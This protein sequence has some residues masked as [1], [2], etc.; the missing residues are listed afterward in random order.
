MK[1]Y[2]LNYFFKALVVMIIILSGQACENHLDYQPRGVV[3]QGDLQN[4]LGAEMLVTAA[5]AALAADDWS[6]AA[7][8]TNWLYGSVRS[9]DAYKGGGSTA[10][11]GNMDRYERFAFILNNQAQQ[12]NVWIAFY[13]AIA[14]A[15]DAIKLI[16]SIDEASYPQKTQRLA[17]M[18][19]LRAHNYFRLVMFFKNIPWIDESIPVE[20]YK[21]ISN[22]EFTQDQLWSKIAEDFQFARDNLPEV[23]NQVGRASAIAAAAYLARTR[24]FQAFEQDDQHNVIN[25]NQTRL[26]EVVALTEFVINSGKH[27]LNE[28]YAFNFVTAYDNSVESV[29]AIQHSYDDGT[30]NGRLNMSFGLNYNMSTRYGCCWFHVPS[31]NMINAFRTDEQGVPLFDTFNDVVVSTPEQFQAHNFDPRISHTVG[32]PGN[33]YK[34]DP[35]FIYTTGWARAPEIYG[36]FSNMKD[37]QHPDSPDFRPVGAFFGSA[38]N[39]DIIRYDDVLLMNAEALIELGRHMEA[40]PGINLIRQRAVNSTNRVRYADGTAP[41]TYNVQPY[42]DG[43]NILWT[44]ANARTALRWERRLEFAMESW[45]FFDLVRWGIAAETLNDYFEVER[46]RRAF[47][48][49]AFF[50]K[51]RNEYLPIPQQQIDLSEGVYQQNPG[52]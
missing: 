24:L 34:Y 35:D 51:N 12:N 10:D 8:T 19:F 46:T 41:L 23:Q 14:R 18:R 47:L 30:P 32:I 49:T 3:S 48:S 9:D 25:V 50:T 6:N 43:Q 4:P 2:N 1:T 45:R 33:P 20:D 22:R 27:S 37:V 42:V 31:Q 44:Q 13:H 28:D 26:N 52:Y 36:F 17:E 7:H 5:Y 16:N 11:Q 29:F 21:L 39:V 38:K 15:N 40:L